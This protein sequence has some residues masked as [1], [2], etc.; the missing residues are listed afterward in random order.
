MNNRNDDS[1]TKQSYHSPHL[2]VHGKIEKLT[3]GGSG[4]MMEMDIMLPMMG[5]TIPD[6]DPTKRP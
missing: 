6:T 5:G 3:T 4:M 1:S 2:R